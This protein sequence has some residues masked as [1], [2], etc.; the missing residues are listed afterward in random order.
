MTN[1][2]RRLHILAEDA[3][4]SIEKDSVLRQGKSL[5]RHLTEAVKKYP[6]APTLVTPQL[7]LN[8]ILS[9]VLKNA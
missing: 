5:Q 9:L 7:H 8:A 4:T 2:L 6:A 1:H 3:R